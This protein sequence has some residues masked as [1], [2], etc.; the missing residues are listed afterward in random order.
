MRGVDAPMGGRR[1]FLRFVW[2]HRGVNFRRKPF[3]T[4]KISRNF[5]SLLGFSTKNFS[6]KRTFNEKSRCRYLASNRWMTQQRKFIEQ[7]DLDFSQNFY[8]G[9]WRPVPILVHCRRLGNFSAANRTSSSD[10]CIL[11][12]AKSDKTNP[13]LSR[14][15]SLSLRSPYSI[16]ICSPFGMSAW[17]TSSKVPR[18]ALYPERTGASYLWLTGR[19]LEQTK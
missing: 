19:L 11:S 7:A 17:A 16:K 4:K 3:L 18:L 8:A 12:Q 5:F 9:K 1:V 14:R 15:Y 13:N 6:T 2:V 10:I